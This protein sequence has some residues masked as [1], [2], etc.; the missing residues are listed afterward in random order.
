MKQCIEEIYRQQQHQPTNWI[1]EPNSLFTF[2]QTH[3]KTND[4]W[5]EGDGENTEFSRDIYWNT[6]LEDFKLLEPPD[7]QIVCAQQCKRDSSLQQCLC[8][9]YLYTYTIGTTHT[10]NP[11]YIYILYIHDDADTQTHLYT[12]MYR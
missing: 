1:D 11:L 8:K 10:H 3:L 9:F 6:R 4:R 7:T 5:E 2:I 12:R